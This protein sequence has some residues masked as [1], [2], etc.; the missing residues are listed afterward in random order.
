MTSFEKEVHAARSVRF[1]T[2]RGVTHEMVRHRPWAY[3]QESTRYVKYNGEMEFIKPVWCSDLVSGKWPANPSKPYCG[4]DSGEELWL[5]A[6]QQQG[7]DYQKLL[8]IGWR[9]EQ[10]RSVLPNS[11]KT[12]IFCT[13]S[14]KEW[15]FM[16]ELRTGKAAHPQIRALMKPVL[17]E[18]ITEIPAVF[19]S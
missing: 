16:L 15:K 3:S 2:D 10:A 4:T 19:T 13:A 11:L 7:S 5:K 9:P 1:I 12:E 6:V 17:E 18:L 8:Q 14:L